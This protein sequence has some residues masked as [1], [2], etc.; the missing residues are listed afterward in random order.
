[1]WTSGRAGVWCNEEKSFPEIEYQNTI[2]EP[3]IQ[4]LM[5][6]I[7][8]LITDNWE[9]ECQEDFVILDF[10]GLLATWRKILIR[11]SI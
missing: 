10:F 7:K 2:L 6:E 8:I 11:L 3:P 5:E 4:T 9:F 1:M